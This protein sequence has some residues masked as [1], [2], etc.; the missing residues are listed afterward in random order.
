VPV[1]PADRDV[2]DPDAAAL[3]AGA[4]DAARRRRRVRFAVAIG[5]LALLAALLGAGAVLVAGA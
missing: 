1:A 2:P 3:L 4:A 5:L